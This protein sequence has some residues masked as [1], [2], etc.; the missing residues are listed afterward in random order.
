MSCWRGKIGAA[1]LFGAIGLRVCVAQTY[2]F[3]NLGGMAPPANYTTI[4]YEINNS[5]Q[6]GGSCTTTDFV[7]G[8]AFR[9]SGGVL[10][11]IGTLGGPH[12]NAFGVNEVG[13][14]TGTADLAG[15]S[16]HHAF[17][18]TNGSMVD[19][20]TSRPTVSSEGV[21]I[22]SSGNV[23]GVVYGAGGVT[24]GAY[25]S[26]TTITD[27]GTLG[28]PSSFAEWMNDSNTAVGFADTASGTTGGFWWN[29]ATGIH[30]I[31]TLGGP[32]SSAQ[33]INNAGV[34]VGDSDVAGGG[35][36]VFTYANG[37][38]TD[39]G[40]LRGD[41]TG[42]TINEAGDITGEMDINGAGGGYLYHNGT[43]ID[44]Q[45]LMPTGSTFH[46]ISGEDV[47]DQGQ[48]LVFGQ[49][50]GLYRT[51]VLTPVPEPAT[52]LA[53]AGGLVVLRRKRKS[54]RSE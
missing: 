49:I 6:V 31:P 27:M 46:I 42:F 22:N 2:T 24:T 48:I 3:T 51:G 33:G 35:H 43:M 30:A 39:I 8:R 36:H 14:V 37:V 26:G 4:G 44:L 18:W 15:G 9:W 16:V 25:F 53:H 21:D 52:I 17:I 5:G 10:Q 50:G 54:K 32:N 45:T 40:S 20:G 28:G 11:D 23:A 41:S 12:A 29:P 38:L 7:T 34:I 13:Q 47:N 1:V 19:T